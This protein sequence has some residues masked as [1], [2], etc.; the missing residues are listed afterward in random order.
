MLIKKIIDH[1]HPLVGFKYRCREIINYLKTNKQLLSLTK[2]SRATL[3]PY[4]KILKKS[5]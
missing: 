2:N 1:F 3:N 4:Q 5:E